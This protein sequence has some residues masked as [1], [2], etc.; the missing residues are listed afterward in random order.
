MKNLKKTFFLTNFVYFLSNC[1][2][3]PSLEKT[4]DKYFNT[5]RKYIEWRLQETFFFHIQQN[6]PF[7]HVWWKSIIILI[8]YLTINFASLRMN[9]YFLI[10]VICNAISSIFAEIITHFAQR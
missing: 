6:D 9:D 3:D 8:I 2:M 4:E 5:N 1:K 10:K 7:Y